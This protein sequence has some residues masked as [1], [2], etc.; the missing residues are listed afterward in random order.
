MSP[1][2][3]SL[4]RTT[5]CPARSTKLATL[6]FPTR[7]PKRPIPASGARCGVAGQWRTLPAPSEFQFPA[8]ADLPKTKS[9]R[10][11]PGKRVSRRKPRIRPA[12]APETAAVKPLCRPDP[13]T[14]QTRGPADSGRS[15]GE[16]FESLPPDCPVEA[17]FARPVAWPRSPRFAASAD[18]FPTRPPFPELH[19]GRRRLRPRP[20]VP[21]PS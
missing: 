21:R 10:R 12:A 3:R 17:R 8:L 9:R 1:G 7:D 15:A 4:S 5:G 13:G 19:D 20:A 6:P 14:S 18:T 16:P 2:R 11:S